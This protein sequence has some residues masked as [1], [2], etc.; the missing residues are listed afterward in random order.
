ML[1]IKSKKKPVPRSKRNRSR[2]KYYRTFPDLNDYTYKNRASWQA[3][4]KMKEE[5]T[6]LVWLEAK[7][8]R[9]RIWRRPVKV[10]F[11]WYEEDR[12]RDL[13]NICAAKKFILD[14][15]VKAHVIPDDSQDYVRNLRDRF[16]IDPTCPRVEVEITDAT[17]RS[18]H[19][20]PRKR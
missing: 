19:E 6:D 1:V 3:G 8:Q 18:W 20:Q 4:K 15:L 7:A 13:D 16:A 10:L 2:T 12:A 11:T 17:S 5:Y 14:G 9:L